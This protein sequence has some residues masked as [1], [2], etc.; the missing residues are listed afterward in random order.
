MSRMLTDMPWFAELSAESRSWVGQILQA[1]IQGF[2][3]WFRLGDEP[4][5]R[6]HARPRSSVRPRAA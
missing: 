5:P 2:V 6:R 3:D 1:G 4:V